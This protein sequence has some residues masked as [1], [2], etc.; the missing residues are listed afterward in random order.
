MSRVF[1]ALFALAAFGLA[2]LY[3]MRLKKIFEDVNSGTL[4]AMFIGFAVLGLMFY[5]ASRDGYHPAGP[6]E[7]IA[8][9]K[10]DRSRRDRQIT[11]GLKSFEME[12]LAL[13]VEYGSPEKVA[14]KLEMEQQ[15]FDSVMDS[16]KTK[17]D[18]KNPEKLISRVQELKLV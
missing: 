8:R 3:A 18:A 6:R 15:E 14:E 13:M 4:L 5:V 2:L 12:V 17:L 16:L 10:K 1:S 7:R 9:A 11:L